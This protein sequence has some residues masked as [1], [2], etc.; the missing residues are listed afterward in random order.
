[1]FNFTHVCKVQVSIKMH[2]LLY[3]YIGQCVL[4]QKNLT[5]FDVATI[6]RQIFSGPFMLD[7]ASSP[8]RNVFLIPLFWTFIFDAGSISD[9]SDTIHFQP[10][11]SLNIGLQF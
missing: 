9:K 4:C 11:K 5:T 2:F 1:M 7:Q 6:S 8:T 3:L 10:H